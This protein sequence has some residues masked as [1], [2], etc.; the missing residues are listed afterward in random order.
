M[1]EDR[2]RLQS[3]QRSTRRK[4]S[5]QDRNS[6][7]VAVNEYLSDSS[8]NGPSIKMASKLDDLVETILKNA[9][10]EAL[11]NIK[12]C[13]SKTDEEKLKEAQVNR[14]YSRIHLWH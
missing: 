11:K 7:F 12:G 8:V 2:K 10:D 9:G 5:D 13:N 1:C 3:L 6:R 14:D 4:E